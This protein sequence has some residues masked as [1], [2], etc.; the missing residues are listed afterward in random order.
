MYMYVYMCSTLHLYIHVHV[1]AKLCIFECCNVAP[2]MNVRTL[3]SCVVG[4][5][6]DSCSCK[7]EEG[8][9][10]GEIATLQLCRHSATR[11]RL[12]T[13]LHYWT[14]NECKYIIHMHLHV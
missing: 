10:G 8:G 11:P 6:S 5:A 14:Q 13:A 7:T 4:V 1:A 12:S 3:M 9:S 2:L